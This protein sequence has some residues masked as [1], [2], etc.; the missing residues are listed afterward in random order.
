MLLNNYHLLESFALLFL[1][2]RVIVVGWTRARGVYKV[3]GNRWLVET[4]RRLG[5]CIVKDKSKNIIDK[6]AVHNNKL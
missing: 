6:I 2:D 1:F 4:L 5:V 3:R